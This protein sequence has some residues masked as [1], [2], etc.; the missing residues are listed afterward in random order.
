MDI[1]G[2]RQ[3]VLDMR[4]TAAAL[5]PGVAEASAKVAAL[6][7]AKV[8]PRIPLGPG[9]A[10]HARSSVKATKSS[11]GGTRVSAGGKKFPYYPWLDY[12]GRVG[13][14]RSIWRPF[15]REGRYVWAEFEDQRA[16]VRRIFNEETTRVVQAGLGDS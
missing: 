14:K 11:R 3:V 5:E 6:I 4:R 7:V 1:E 12:G 8:R 16:A 9:R 13:P 15:I 10:G 2:V